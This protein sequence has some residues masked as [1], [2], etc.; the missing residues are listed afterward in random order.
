MDATR[1]PTMSRRGGTYCR[2]S[3]SDAIDSKHSV[4]RESKVRKV[5]YFWRSLA[6][7]GK[8]G[9]SGFFFRHHRSIANPYVDVCARREDDRPEFTQCLAILFLKI[10][11]VTKSIPNPA[12]IAITMDAIP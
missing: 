7:A 4:F 12:S 5:V 3:W 6:S 8:A 10:R 11:D 9:L 2:S 1:S